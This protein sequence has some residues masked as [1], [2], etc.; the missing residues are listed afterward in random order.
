MGLS[1]K[2]LQVLEVEKAVT[3][4]LF[5]PQFVQKPSLPENGDDKEYKPHDLVQR[6]KVQVQPSDSCTPARRAKRM[7]A[8]VDQA[9]NT[10]AYTNF[11]SGLINHILN[12]AVEL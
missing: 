1:S 4:L 3:F 11:T 5:H 8:E 12:T 7:K 2:L 9:I 10:H 6:Q